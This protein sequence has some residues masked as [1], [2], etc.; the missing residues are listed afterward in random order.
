MLC[1]VRGYRRSR[2]SFGCGI[3]NRIP[4]TVN[5]HS[6]FIPTILT[7][8]AAPASCSLLPLLLNNLQHEPT[9]K[10]RRTMLLRRL[11]K[12]LYFY[13]SR[14]LLIQYYPTTKT[15]RDSHCFAIN[16]AVRPSKIVAACTTKKRGT[17]S[18]RPVRRSTHRT[19]QQRKQSKASPSHVPTSHCL[20]G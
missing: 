10:T 11:T 18:R 1:R 12:R 2:T 7:G 13:S 8:S 15:S 9:T 20:W 4:Y 6:P 3:G 5:R 14:E 16:I 19:I 17:N